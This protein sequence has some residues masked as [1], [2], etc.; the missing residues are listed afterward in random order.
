MK[1]FALAVLTLALA[2]CSGTAGPQGPEGPKGDTGATGPQGPAGAMGA[3]GAMGVTGA[4]GATGG[5]LYVSRDAAYCK[6]ATSS[7][8]SYFAEVSCDDLNDLVITGGC[9][10]ATAPTG[11]ILQRNYPV[12]GTVSQGGT[13]GTWRCL[14]SFAP[15]VT[16]VFPNT[17]G[18]K[19][20]ICC[21]TV[22]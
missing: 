10:D 15:G 14:W 4:T 9:S 8:N 19:A 6:E 2:A 12:P 7:G 11:T 5:G 1:T 20:H 22:P 21:I 18:A 3:T 16:P 17:F 13:P